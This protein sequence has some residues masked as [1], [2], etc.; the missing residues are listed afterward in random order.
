MKALMRLGDLI[1]AFD[2]A[3]GPPPRAGRLH[4]LVPAGSWPVLW[5]AGILS[6]AAGATEVVSALILGWVIDAALE[7]GPAGFF[8]E[9]AW[10]LFWF[11]AFYLICGR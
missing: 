3:D 1:D 8:A 4:A 11:L 10:L 7:S 6:A 5:V 9:H 2:P